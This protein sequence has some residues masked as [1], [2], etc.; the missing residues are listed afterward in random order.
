MKKFS[1]LLILMLSVL[2]GCT[3][4]DKKVAV[5]SPFSPPQYLGK[6]YEIARLDHSFERGMTHVTAEY[7]REDDSIKV[8]NRGFDTASDK[9]ESANG[10]A[11][12]T[13]GDNTGRLRVTFFWPFYGA[14]QI[15]E[16]IP[17]PPQQDE[18]YQVSLVMGPNS[19]YMWILARTPQISDEI[20]QQLVAKAV[21]LGVD[22]N[23]IIWVDQSP[24]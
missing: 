7:S 1:I 14:Y 21:A 10:T 11:Y 3:S 8:I 19:D 6:W 4:L 16:I 24:K 12:F 15:H 22:P 17:N 5:V 18:P 13:D 2:T 20:K 9:W 23:G